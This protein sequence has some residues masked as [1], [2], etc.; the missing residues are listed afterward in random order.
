MQY[1]Y[2][3]N[4]IHVGLILR[5]QCNWSSSFWDTSIQETQNLAPEN[6]HIVFVSITS[7]KGKSHLYSEEKD[8]FSGSG[9]LGLF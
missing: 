7:I 4:L 8:T 3:N 5:K 9:N 2:A 1:I 6:V